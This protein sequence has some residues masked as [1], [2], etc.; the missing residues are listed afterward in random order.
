VV[1]VDG[2]PYAA[3]VVRG[4]DSHA[5]TA[6]ALRLFAD[7]LGVL[8]ENARQH[9]RVSAARIARER[10][11]ALG[12]AAAVLAHEVR[13]PLAVLRSASVLVERED[14]GVRREAAEMIREEVC[15]LELLVR[16]LLQ[17]ARPLEP[18]PV[19][20]PIG[21]LARAAVERAR[22]VDVGRR[23]EVD[24]S[25]EVSINVDPALFALAIGNLVRNALDSARATGLVR[26]SLEAR[27]NALVVAV[28]DDG[29]GV[30][31]SQ[32]ARI[33]EAFYT[34]RAA[35]TGLGLS[36]AKRI[37]EA[38]GG[39]IDVRCSILGGARFE[40]VLPIDLVTRRGVSS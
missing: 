2:A 12:E 31:A 9:S 26:L 37:V 23:V 6:A 18:R 10:F 13:N 8:I 36:I 29:D 21:V 25:D 33:F 3:F 17:L 5:A 28:D 27:E 22:G 20:S 32:A 19:P 34:T 11:T 40:V 15:R 30:D 4:S 24:V 16:D 14:R 39:V 1:S 7:H 38:H 35:G